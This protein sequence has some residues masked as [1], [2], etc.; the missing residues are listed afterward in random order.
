M[1]H[2]IGGADFSY[3]LGNDHRCIEKGMKIFLCCPL[4]IQGV[5]VVDVVDF[6]QQPV[7]LHHDVNTLDQLIILFP[8]CLREVMRAQVAEQTS[9]A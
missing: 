1:R 2:K 9:S 5:G 6:C 7:F 8:F 3:M 4:D